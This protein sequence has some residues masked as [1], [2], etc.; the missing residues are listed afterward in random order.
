M[1]RVHIQR[2]EALPGYRLRLGLSDGSTIE[3]DFAAELAAPIGPMDAPLQD[4]A[5]FAQVRV[6]PDLQTVVWPNGYDMDPDALM[7]DGAPP[8]AMSRHE[9]RD[10]QLRRVQ[11]TIA[12]AQAQLRD[13]EVKREAFRRRHEAGDKGTP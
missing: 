3:R 11:Q 10:E 9:Q 4:P 8:Y 2:V 1:D 7:Y 12:E 5:F 13:L 6:D